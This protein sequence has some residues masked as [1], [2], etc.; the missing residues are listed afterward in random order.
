[1][2][3]KTS[4]TNGATVGTAQ[5]RAG[6]IGE[7]LYRGDL[8]SRPRKKNGISL[9]YDVTLGVDVLI[10]TSHWEYTILVYDATLEVD[11]L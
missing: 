6:E 11:V 9:F 7:I 3:H 5:Y 8:S 2:L 4:F 1:M 10:M